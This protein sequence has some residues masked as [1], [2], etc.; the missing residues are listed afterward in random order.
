MIVRITKAP[1]GAEYVYT[2]EGYRD[3]RGKAMQRIVAKHGRLDELLAADPEALAKLKQKAAA[4]TEQHR[5][6]WGVVEYDTR[7]PSD[8]VGAKNLGWWLADAVLQRLGVTGV[9]DE[10]AAACGWGLDVAGVLRVLV[11]SQVVWP[12]SKRA[13]AFKSGRLYGGIEM[14]LGRVY[15][16]LDHVAGLS[17]RLQE[18]AAA[19]VRRP[20]GALERVDY[21]V[22]NYFFHI[23][24][25]DP[26]PTGI[27]GARG[28]ATRQRGHSKENRVEP[29][30]QLGLFTDVE[31]IPI[32]FR[33]F[34][35]NIP[36]TSTLPMALADFKAGHHPGRVVVVADK[37]MN[38]SPNTGLLASNGDGWIVSASAR[39]ADAATTAW[40]L[41]PDG[42]D[43]HGAWKTKSKTVTRPVT[44]PDHT[45]T[46]VAEK[47]VS[48]WSAESAFR[49]RNVR[50]EMLARA[51]KLA[52][53][54]AAFKASNK[55]GVKK[56]ISA[57]TVDPATGEVL[58][59]EEL[60]L[61]V[62]QARANGE[63]LLDGYQLIRTSETALPDDEIIDRHHQLWR[64]E[65]AFRITKTDLKTRPVYVWTPPHIEAHFLIC[66]LALLVT[67]L[68]EHFTGLPSGQLL[69]AL[70]RFEAIDCGHGIHRLSR[71]TSWNTID[72]ALGVALNQQWATTPQIHAWTL[73]LKQALADID[74][75]TTPTTH[76]NHTPL[77]E[78][79]H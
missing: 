3:G 68:L 64:I 79:I 27:D 10:M 28:G 51:G 29:I 58:A 57:T 32:G 69:D 61:T 50:T 37:A 78:N 66:Y 14:D 65:A 23:D 72:E 34:D 74:Y 67:K 36:D 40:I 73:R 62:D 46:T 31:G 5:A 70:R 53:N 2:V 8:G 41:D 52:A 38:T 44:L 45:K 15:R 30:I 77:S 17:S 6:G 60:L 20:E 21:D 56:Y 39:H 4:M 63:A 19:G 75:T 76:N 43:D 48:S 33:L 71:P 26:Q 22:S 16:V 55:K 7:I 9:A 24:D 12:G 42:W 54:P 49:D 35:G 11:A 25:P 47:L 13:A 1:N 59:D 18:V